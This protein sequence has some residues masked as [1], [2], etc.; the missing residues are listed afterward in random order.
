MFEDTVKI[1]AHLSTVYGFVF[2]HEFT[3]QSNKSFFNG[4]FSDSVEITSCEY[5]KTIIIRSK[6]FS[7]SDWLK[8]HS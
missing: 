2:T 4:F 5:T 8:S 1:F 6:Y 7:I 3:R